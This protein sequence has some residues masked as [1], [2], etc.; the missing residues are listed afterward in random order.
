[1]YS[2]KKKIAMRKVNTKVKVMVMENSFIGDSTGMRAS[3]EPV[4]F[5]FLS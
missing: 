4:M 5:Y 1:M 2:K 3:K